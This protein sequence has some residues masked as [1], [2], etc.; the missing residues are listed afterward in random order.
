MDLSLFD[1]FRQQYTM[2][3]AKWMHNMFDKF[4]LFTVTWQV[5]SD[6]IWVK[7][8]EV[9]LCKVNDVIQ[10]FCIISHT[11]VAPQMTGFKADVFT[12]DVQMP[13]IT[14]TQSHTD[15][16]ETLLLSL[17]VTHDNS[18]SLI[19]SYLNLGSPEYSYN[20]SWIR[21]S[22]LLLKAHQHRRVSLSAVAF[23]PLF[24]TRTFY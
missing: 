3:R 22:S 20:I 5:K 8:G 11:E 6:S 9:L 1:T 21:A 23:V 4:H 2:Q 14:D 15:I 10:M 24:T 16:V 17:L 13:F 19:C 18:T 12:L 7:A